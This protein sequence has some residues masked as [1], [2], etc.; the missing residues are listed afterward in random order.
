MVFDLSMAN[1]SGPNAIEGVPSVA[2]RDHPE[3]MT[4]SLA[5]PEHEALAR[6]AYGIATQ[7]LKDHSEAMDVASET[8][9][10]LLARFEPPSNNESYV[11]TVAKNL[12]KNKLRGLNRQRKRLQW[13][14]DQRPEHDGHDPDRLLSRLVIEEAVKTLPKRQREAITYCYLEGMDRS[15]AARRMGVEVA[16]VKTHLKRAFR[17]LRE[18]LADGAEDLR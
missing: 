7:I 16:S 17:A 12:A 2:R 13:W 6:I 15:S 14:T 10:T 1:P 8:M 5:R 11:T 18:D 4:E 9:I 3:K